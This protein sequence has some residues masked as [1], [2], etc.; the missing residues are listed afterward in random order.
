MTKE[1]PKAASVALALLILSSIMAYAITV[2]MDADMTRYVPANV[3]RVIGN[4]LIIGNNCTAIIAETSPERALSIENGMKGIIDI[5]PNTHDT[6]VA[7]LR[8][9]N[10]TLESV[11]MDR[12]DGS[13]YYSDLNLKTDGK[14]LKLDARPSDAI[15][16]AVRTNSTVYINKTMLQEEGQN[17][18]A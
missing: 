12:F 9:F 16:I 3:I 11:T 8:S 15:A 1:L 4:T 10:I 14:M 13:N 2:I 5:R 17:I 7:T 18:C 6:F